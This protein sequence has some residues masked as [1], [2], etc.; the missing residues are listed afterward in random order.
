L[1]TAIQS[2]PVKPYRWGKIQ[3]WMN[4]LCGFW[5]LLSS[6]IHGE[7]PFR[8]DSYIAAFALIL[9]GIGL[10]SKRRYG[11]YLFGLQGMAMALG[12]YWSGWSSVFIATFVTLWMIPAVFYY[13]KRWKDFSKHPL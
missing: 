5:L 12:V 13:P 11:L 4:I 2:A 10:I 3:G 7:A 1:E 6:P 9:L 8:I